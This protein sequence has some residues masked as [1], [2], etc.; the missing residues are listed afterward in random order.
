MWDT[1][2]CLPF[3]RGGFQDSNTAYWTAHEAI[4]RSRAAGEAEDLL[5]IYAVT[6]HAQWAGLNLAFVSEPVNDLANLRKRIERAAA[7]YRERGLGWTLVACE[8]WIAPELRPAVPPLCRELS[9]TFA[10]ETIGMRGRIG[11]EPMPPELEIRRVTTPEMRR[12]FADINAEGWGVP[13]NY[14]REILESDAFWTDSM[15][16]YLGFVDN[17]PVSVSMGFPVEGTLYLTWGA[18]RA[19]HRRR[20]YAEA[21]VRHT[22]L[23]H[24]TDRDAQFVAT[25]NVVKI[26]ARR[27][28]Q[29]VA[30]FALYVSADKTD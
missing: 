12:S 2:L 29:S 9:L 23:S 24:G 20:G 7:F 10:I 30:K 21:L 19:T 5:G 18:T 1:E 22:A 25:P 3:Y 26:W 11:P 16:G 6:P 17:E 13:V 28:F 14:T 27:G 15:E 8:E 4:A